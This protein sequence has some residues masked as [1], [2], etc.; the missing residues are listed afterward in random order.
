M[1]ILNQSIAVH[2]WHSS[3]HCHAITS[4]EALAE[5]YLLSD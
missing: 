5:D 1:L 4:F 2:T 3:P